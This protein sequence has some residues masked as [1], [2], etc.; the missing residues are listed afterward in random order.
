MEDYVLDF[1]S[2]PWEINAAS[3]VGEAMIAI[4]IANGFSE[5]FGG[6]SIDEIKRNYEGYIDYM[7]R[8]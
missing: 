5:K 2:L 6:D 7:K 8:I 3:V 1:E 4:E